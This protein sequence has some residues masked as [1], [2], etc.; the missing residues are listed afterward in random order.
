[1][2]QQETDKGLFQVQAS[3]RGRIQ[4]L[5]AAA[6]AAKNRELFS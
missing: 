1:M 3:T 4:V 6:E 5:T 2:A